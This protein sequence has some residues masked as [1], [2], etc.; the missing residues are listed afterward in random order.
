MGS[1][2]VSDQVSQ[3]LLTAYCGLVTAPLAYPDVFKSSGSYAHTNPHVQMRA[4]GKKHRDSTWRAWRL[5]GALL[6]FSAW[7]SRQAPCLQR[8]MSD[9]TSTEQDVLAQLQQQLSIRRKARQAA[10]ES[11]QRRQKRVRNGESSTDQDSAAAAGW[12][13]LQAADA[14][15]LSWQGCALWGSV[16]VIVAGWCLSWQ[17][18]LRFAPVIA[19]AA[20]VYGV[21]RGLL[22]PDEAAVQ[23]LAAV[24]GAD[25]TSA[26]V[27]SYL[28][29]ML[30]HAGPTASLIGCRRSSLVKC[31]ADC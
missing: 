24:F 5:S 7:S 10:L 13:Q 28:S 30:E 15:S 23:Q 19:A 8:H 31:I 26:T 6:E 2:H 27:V 12:D 21:S 29:C 9:S 16:L 11:A 22:L 25:G 14:D 18:A 20:V 4:Q 17:K 1:A 3:T